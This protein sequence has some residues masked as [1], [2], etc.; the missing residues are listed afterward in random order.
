[1]LPISS[2]HGQLL[3]RP[4]ASTILPL[5][6]DWYCSDRKHIDPTPAEFE[7]V[8]VPTSFKVPLDAHGNPLDASE[9]AEAEIYSAADS[10]A[11]ASE[12]QAEFWA[13]DEEC[14]LRRRRWNQRFGNPYTR[15]GLLQIAFEASLHSR[16]TADEGGIPEWTRRSWLAQLIVYYPPVL[17]RLVELMDLQTL[18]GLMG[19]CR[20]LHSF[21][22]EY[23]PAWRHIS[24][25]V[26]KSGF[27]A[28]CEAAIV[29]DA[30]H[31]S[32]HGAWTGSR[33][34]LTYGAMRLDGA[35]LGEE[36]RLL[37]SLPLAGLRCLDLDGSPAAGGRGFSDILKITRNTLQVLSV[38][39]CRF[40]TAV[41]VEKILISCTVGAGTGDEDED[42][43]EDDDD[44]E[45]PAAAAAG[46][47]CCYTRLPDCALRTLQIWGIQGGERVSHHFRIFRIV[48]IGRKVRKVPADPDPDRTTLKTALPIE[49]SRTFVARSANSGTAVALDHHGSFI[50]GMFYIP[51]SV[52]KNGRHVPR[53]LHPLETAGR[54]LVI[55]RQ[56]GIETDFEDCDAGGDCWNHRHVKSTSTWKLGVPGLKTARKCSSC[57][58]TKKETL[59]RDCEEHRACFGCKKAVCRDCDPQFLSVGNQCEPCSV[60]G[61]FYCKDCHDATVEALSELAAAKGERGAESCPGGVGLHGRGGGN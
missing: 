36:M 33:L 58:A 21:L 51:H 18:L 7:P 55:A 38:R 53:N 2:R 41:D 28:E 3:L 29:Q 48:R 6:S 57:G 54:V 49:L 1:M 8:A 16:R 45:E 59:C 39:F 26:R 9:V 61:R 47:G 14:V 56:L 40:M 12:K 27:R 13:W 31:G 34:R 4:S 50:N 22:L 52:R 37:S 17:E 44:D 11:A 15:L 35:A 43:D 5:N 19:C 46:L 23:P 25:D 10:R 42:E 20:F 30:Q 24:F 32:K 60:E